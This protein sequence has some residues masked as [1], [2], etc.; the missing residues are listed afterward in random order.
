MAKSAIKSRA[1]KPAQITITYDLFDLP[2]AQHKA[3]L[4]GL[5]LQIESMQSRKL[6]APVFRWDEEQ[7]RTKVHVDFT[8]ETT[9]SLFN[10][11][12]DAT[13]VEGQPREKPFSKGK[14]DAKRVIPPLRRVP[15][16]KRD[17]KGKETTVDGYVY[18]ELTP[19]LS[20]LRHYLPSQGEW[21]RL[22][23]DLLWQVVREG[24]KKAPFIGRAGKKMQVPEGALRA[25]GDAEAS[26]EKEDAKADGSSW[27]DL[28]KV[29]A[30]HASGTFP[31][32]RLSGALL[33]GAMDKNAET[34]P[35]V[36]RIEHS[37]L[38]HFWPLTVLVFVPRFIDQDGESH[39]GRRSSKS[40]SPHFAIVV[41]EVS[42]L[43]GFI[44]D[45][46]RLLASLSSE[47]ASF[48]PRESVID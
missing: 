36:S 10:D 44:N 39:L 41:P 21:V 24:R 29:Q 8:P 33:L 30:A 4:A 40:S 19:A 9:A 26:D 6:P 37:L 20:T 15:M 18:L 14:G 28:E 7:P 48:R 13:L 32:G 25:E 11:L 35:L 46:P 12:Y 27:P 43:C 45:C 3:G 34:L 31:V 16:T 23:R 17:K 1:G 5:L 47:M 38:L 42:D 22:W 2:T